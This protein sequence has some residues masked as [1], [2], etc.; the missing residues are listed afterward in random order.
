MGSPHMIKDPPTLTLFGPSCPHRCCLCLL[1]GIC[2]GEGASAPQPGASRGAFWAG[3]EETQASVSALAVWSWAR[4]PT[5]KAHPS[6][7]WPHHVWANEN[8]WKL[9][10]SVCTNQRLRQE[11]FYLVTGMGTLENCW[12][13]SCKE[14]EASG[15]WRRSKEG[16]ETLLYCYLKPTLLPGFLPQPS[17]TRESQGQSG[18][19][20]PLWS[21]PCDS[22]SVHWSCGLCWDTA[23][24]QELTTCQA[25][26]FHL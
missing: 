24:D 8:H 14:S 23:G 26:P 9:K 2:P 20:L 11:H 3:G 15:P 7:K 13:L 21:N 18:L 4:Q 6:V 10:E 12:S 5:S 16:S 25:F 22:N 19:S 17:I 1:S